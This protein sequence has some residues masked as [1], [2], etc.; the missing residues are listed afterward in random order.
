LDTWF[1]SG[2]WPFATVGWPNNNNNNNNDDAND[3]A[4][5][6]AGRDATS[7]EAWKALRDYQKFYPATVLETGYDILFFW[8]ARM[9]MMGMQLT[10]K[11]PFEVW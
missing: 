1:S 8:V 3:D 11:P 6:N 9:V 10:G 2:L 4:S 7:T 5:A